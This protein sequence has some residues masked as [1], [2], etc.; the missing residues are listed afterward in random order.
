[1]SIILIGIKP[2]TVPD[3]GRLNHILHIVPKRPKDEVRNSEETISWKKYT[4]AVFSKSG[5]RGNYKELSDD[6]IL[7][8]LT[9]IQKGISQ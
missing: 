2:H 3:I 5:F 4:Y 6:T 7:M 1:V 8:G 9:D